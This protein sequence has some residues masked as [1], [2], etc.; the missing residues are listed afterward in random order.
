M[1]TSA[2][3]GLRTKVNSKRPVKLDNIL[4]ATDFSPASE[5]AFGYALAIA[6]RYDSKLFVAHVIRPDVYHML[7]PE[8]LAGVLEQIRRYAEQEMANLLISGRL[9]GIPHQI[10]LE[11]GQLWTV[12]SGMMERNDIDLIVVGTRGRTGVQKLLLGSVAEEIFRLS[13]R[14]VL[15]VGPTVSGRAPEETQLR[16]I[17]YATDFTPAAEQA[18]AYALSLAQE[19]Q[20]HLTLLH[21]VRD[22]DKVS[23]ES[24]AR[25]QEFF[26]K[27]L[28]KI[29]PPETNL[30]CDPEFA[31]AFGVPAEGILEIA[32]NRHADLI[33]L[34]VR[35]VPSFAG[36]LPPATAYKVVCQAP[37]PVLTVRG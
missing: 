11:Q 23:P 7:P 15:T 1:V 26:V 34:G 9:R 37:C 28:E 2:D 32:K 19:H 35:G 8:N 6:R 31:V 21:V 29:V 10:L 18:A 5:T 36:H 27:R 14:P 13:Q 22:A 16:Q 24:I 20:A 3:F 30:W 12:L 17:V 4:F 25:L 33:V